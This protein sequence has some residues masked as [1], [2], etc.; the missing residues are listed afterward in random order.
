[1]CGLVYKQVPI[2][3]RL[4]E[5]NRKLDLT[6]EILNLHPEFLAYFVL[7]L[8]VLLVTLNLQDDKMQDRKMADRP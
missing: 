8:H 5:E 3:S 4:I 7:I 2:H 1:M 6:F